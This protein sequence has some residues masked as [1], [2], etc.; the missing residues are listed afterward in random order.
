MDQQNMTDKV[1]QNYIKEVYRLID[2]GDTTEGSFYSSLQKLIE[3]YG[4]ILGKKTH[5][6]VLPKKTEA[7]NPDFRIW[8]GESVITGYI[9][10]KH[11]L[12]KHLEYIENTE[13]LQRYKDAYQNLILT[14][15]LEF[16]LYRN[17]N[18]WKEAKI[19]DYKLAEI[20][21]S[22][23]AIIRKEKFIELLNLFFEFVQPKIRTPRV[24]AEILSKKAKIMRDYIILPGL[25]EKEEYFVALYKSF[26][27]HLLRDLAPEAFADLFA[28]TFTY[29]LF[30]AKYQFE[31]E[32]QPTLFSKRKTQNIPFTTKTAYSFIQKSFGILREIFRVIS[33]EDMPKNLEIIV[34]D[35]ID[36]LNHTDI[37]KLLTHYN[38]GKKKDPIYH[39]YETFLLNYDPERKKKLGIFYTPPEVVSFIV[40]S[41]NLLLK[42]RKFFDSPDGLATYK[43]NSSKDSVTLLDPAVGTGTFFIEAIDKALE[44][45]KNKYSKSKDFITQFIRNHILKHFFAF[46]I[47][48]APYVVSHLKTLFN[49]TKQGF[50]FTENDKLNIFLTNTLE[51]HRKET[52]GGLVGL[53]EKVLVTEQEK[54]LEVKKKIPILVIIGNPPYSVSSQ[55]K[56][57]P[58][59]SFGKFYESYK[60][61]VRKEERNIQPLSDDYI[62][63]LAFAHW[64]I[65]QTG[66]GIVG[67]ITNNSYLDGLIHRDMRKKLYNDFDLIYILNLHG[68]AKRP[69][70][71][72]DGRKDENVFDIRQ[73]VAIGIFAKTQ[74]KVKKQIFYYELIGEREEKYKFLDTHSVTNI[75]WEKLEPKPPYWF[76]V[77]K[78]FK[79]KEN[80]QGFYSIKE[81]FNKYTRGTVTS[82]DDFVIDRN[83][84]TLVNRI[85]SFINSDLSPD[86]LK[87]TFKLKDG[88]KWKT[89]NAQRLLKKK[90]FDELLIYPYSY[91]PFDDQ[92]IYYDEILLERSRSSLM[93]HMFRNNIALIAMRQVYWNNYSHFFITR[94]ITDSRIFISKRGAAD[95]FPLWLYNIE[96][97]TQNQLLSLNS[98][99]PKKI[100]NI[101]KEIIDLLSYSYKKSVSPEGIFY[102]IYTVLY[103]NIYRQKYL[104]FLKIDFPR[105]P[106][107]K[108]YKLFKQLSEIGKKLIDIHLLKSPLLDK[109]SSKFEGEGGLNLVKKVIYNSN[110]KRVYINKD[111]YFENV[112]PEIWNYF[113]GGYQVLNK[114]LKDRKGRYLNDEEIKTYIKIIEAIRHTIK[115]Q[116]EIDKL[117]PQIEERLLT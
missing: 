34:D 6:T 39:L 104:E 35:I 36:I 69:K 103:S 60:E 47:L 90:G 61:K 55:N 26:K 18:F 46:E 7:G 51:F 11:P 93:K 101:K 80:Y 94:N 95:I 38:K 76:F 2:Q 92:W 3:D 43:S 13:Q 98:E 58:K 59:T 84:N 45:V 64:K 68:D 107:T 106:F 27:S 10:A 44:E 29:G 19:G 75:K 23:P 112:E 42:N 56:V 33:T 91:R 5:V 113:I 41:V 96:N 72:K 12:T 24:L 79:G 82:R 14:N 4:K 99:V 65:Y 97:K 100:S 54:A 66:K 114:W 15:F 62:K 108:D 109:T 89:K 25:Q 117:Y 77:P 63:F 102:Y 50:E 40:N 81:I 86:L 17:G 37:Y 116:K 88:K 1:F 87:E 49:L 67:M 74:K 85:N 52:E 115:I 48:I 8:D 73:G 105:V 78:E 21:L 9:E 16:R 70:T 31:I 71:T 30:I 20:S 22:H 110:E 57:D 28:Q 53:F 32:K 111:Q 83:K